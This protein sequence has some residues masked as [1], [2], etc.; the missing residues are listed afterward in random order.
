MQTLAPLLPICVTLG[1]SF[2]FSVLHEPA[3]V[4]IAPKTIVRI[5]CIVSYKVLV[6][7]TKCQFLQLVP[8]VPDCELHAGNELVLSVC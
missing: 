3:L 1:K 4:A 6:T 8:S 2:H 7:V 5:K